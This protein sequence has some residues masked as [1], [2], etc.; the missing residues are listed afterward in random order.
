MNKFK[1]KINKNIILAGIIKINFQPR[2]YCL[3]KKQMIT[4]NQ[5]IKKINP[6]IT[7][8]PSRNF[9]FTS[10]QTVSTKLL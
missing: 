4:T 3:R 1:V 7:G 2:M 5:K 10:L 6:I 8:R 9:T